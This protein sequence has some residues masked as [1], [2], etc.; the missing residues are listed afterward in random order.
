V[1]L[2]FPAIESHE[3]AAEGPQDLAVPRD[4]GGRL[5]L[6]ED[7]D[8]V[9]NATRDVLSAMGCNVDHVGSGEAAL[10]F[11]VAHSDEIDAVISDVE[12]PGPID[13][14]ALAEHIRGA[15]PSLPVILMTG[16]AQRIEQAAQRGLDVLPK[17]VPPRLLAEAIARALDAATTHA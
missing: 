5:L 12:M 8:A 4:I 16:Y 3:P 6:V 10:A 14:I 7:N 17:P 2:Y 11:L 9:A 15:Y 1:L 13:G